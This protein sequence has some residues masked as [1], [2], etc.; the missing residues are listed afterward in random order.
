MNGKTNCQIGAVGVIAIES[1]VSP[2]AKTEKPKPTTG[3]GWERSTILPT[4][5]ASRPL[6]IAIGA[7]SRAERV[8]DNPHT[9]CA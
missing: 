8:G 3:R 2:I 6:V 1:Q 7:V 5:G 4:I 9:A